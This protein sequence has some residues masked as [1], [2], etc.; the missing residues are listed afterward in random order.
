MRMREWAEFI[1]SEALRPKSNGG[2]FGTI[3]EM[4]SHE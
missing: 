3:G 2:K 1:D 4:R